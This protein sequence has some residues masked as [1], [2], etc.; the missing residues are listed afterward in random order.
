MAWPE[1]TTGGPL[2]RRRYSTRAVVGPRRWQRRWVHGRR[3]RR[4][5]RGRRRRVEF[6]ADVEA[7]GAG[8]GTQ[9]R[10]DLLLGDPPA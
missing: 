10:D 4:R 8:G 1:P 7:P 6:V 2:G 5:D 9:R 3:G